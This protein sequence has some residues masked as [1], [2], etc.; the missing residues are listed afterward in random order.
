MELE[1]DSLLNPFGPIYRPKQKDAG[2]KS[3]LLRNEVSHST[4]WPKIRDIGIIDTGSVRENCRLATNESKHNATDDETER[5]QNVCQK[6][7]H[8]SSIGA[9]ANDDKISEQQRKVHWASASPQVSSVGA[10]KPANSKIQQN[11]GRFLERPNSWHGTYPHKNSAAE[12]PAYANNYSNEVRVVPQQT[13]QSKFSYHTSEFGCP[14][15]PPIKPIVSW[16]A[17]SEG[18]VQPGAIV[19]GREFNNPYTFI[20]RVTLRNER[21]LKE[22]VTQYSILYSK[23]YLIFLY[24]L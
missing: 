12:Q 3:S 23:S 7:S 19:A 22:N 20:G 11:Y 16:V 1:E 24:L 21:F 18:R 5:H 15:K 14:Y 17:C 13:D 6:V 9:S 2:K 4:R 8:P 10:A